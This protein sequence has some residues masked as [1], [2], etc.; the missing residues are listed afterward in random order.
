MLLLL[1][2]LLLPFMFSYFFKAL[3]GL[4][5]D[6]TYYESVKK[7]H[8]RYLRLTNLW[9]MCHAAGTAIHWVLLEMLFFQ[10][11][12]CCCYRHMGLRVQLLVRSFCGK[13]GSIA[14]ADIRVFEPRS[15]G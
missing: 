7:M 4:I 13:R 2:L 15:L 12:F 1:L 14:S 5:C 3:H 6:Y 8:Y 9:T 11:C 10:V